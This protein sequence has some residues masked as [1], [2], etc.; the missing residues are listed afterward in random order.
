MFLNISYLCRSNTWSRVSA[1]VF[2]L[3]FL[4]SFG[5]SEA[6]GLQDCCNETDTKENDSNLP[7]EKDWG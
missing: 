4:F 3:S 7:F 6:H 5:I 2:V 1:V